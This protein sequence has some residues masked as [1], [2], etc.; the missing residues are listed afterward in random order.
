MSSALVSPPLVKAKSL[1]CPNCGAAIELRGF[2]HTLNAV[3]PNCLSILD[4]SSPEFQILQTFQGK[5]RIEPKIPLGSRGTFNGTVYEVIGFQERSVQSE[6]DLFSWDE[7]LLFN[8]Y[9]GFRYLTEY[10]GHW[11]VVRVLSRLPD[12]ATARGRPAKRLDGRNYAA[13]DSM[14]ATTSYVIGEFPWQV[15]CG[16]SAACEDF[17]SPSYMLSSETTEGETTWSLG[18]YWEGSKIWQAFRLSGSPPYTQGI[19]ANQPSPYAGKSG[20]AWRTWL[21]FNVALFALMMLF[22]MTKANHEVFH[23][24]YVYVAGKNADTAFVTRSFELSGGDK[25]VEVGAHAAIDNDWIYLN[26]AL[27]NDETGQA[28]DFAREVSYYHDS[29]GSEG[30]RDNKVVIPSVPGGRYYLRVEPE[31][32]PSAPSTRYEIFVRRDVPI[33]SYFWIAAALLLIPPIATW[34]RANQFEARRWHE[35]DYQP[36]QTPALKIAGGIIESLGD[37]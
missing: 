23:D 37:D 36:V 34:F 1:S 3:C 28:F 18:E 14:T 10:L 33:Y 20:S 9:K 8:P 4:A 26:F 11:N 29:D 27:I 5:E 22:S 17:I 12:I 21:W 31:M 35:S 13:F 15:R 32:S 30:S 25:N 19:S 7:Y 16:D 2:A 24:D 6:D